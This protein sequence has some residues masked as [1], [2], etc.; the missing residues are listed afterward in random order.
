MTTPFDQGSLTLPDTTEQTHDHVVGE[1]GV[2][3]LVIYAVRCT[4]GWSSPSATLG[5][6]AM[7]LIK[8]LGDMA[9][10][11][12]AGAPTGVHTL[13]PDGWSGRIAHSAASYFG[14]DQDNPTADLDFISL[15]TGGSLPDTRTL[16][17]QLGQLGV[18]VSGGGVGNLAPDFN[19]VD[20]DLLIERVWNADGICGAGVTCPSC[21]IMDTPGA[22]SV[23]LEVDGGGT[24]WEHIA[25]ALRPAVPARGRIVEYLYNRSR[26][27]Q[28]I[29]S[30]GRNVPRAQIRTNRFMRV[31]GF[32][33][34]TAEAFAT[35]IDDP[36]VSY[37]AARRFNEDS[38]R[39]EI[40]ADRASQLESILSQLAAG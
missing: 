39:V 3:S 13:D 12:Y 20:P 30:R 23:D 22:T 34:P 5:G 31:D 14:V 2:N 18:S 26:P 6:A 24:S 28:I 36:S 35:N 25:F 17:S 29:D 32:L 21:V 37:I 7:T 8:Q 15:A 33:Y 16:A 27:R 4:A 1:T 9:V 40:E 10:F 38:N 11:Y 19:A